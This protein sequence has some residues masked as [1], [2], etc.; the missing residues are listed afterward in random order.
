MI[1]NVYKLPPIDKFETYQ[2][3]AFLESEQLPKDRSV[4][5]YNKAIDTTIEWLLNKM[6][7]E[8]HAKIKEKAM[9]DGYCT[10]GLDSIYECKSVIDSENQLWTLS[11]SQP[12]DGRNMEFEPTPGRIIT[13]NI[14]YHCLGNSVLAAVK[15]TCIQ[16]Y[17]QS[18]KE[19]K[20]ICPSFV[21]S[22][23]REIGLYQGFQ[24]TNHPFRIEKLSDIDKV[25]AYMESFDRTLP[26]L[27]VSQGS[28]NAD[29]NCRNGF[30][31]DTGA[32]A[33]KLLGY[34]VVIELPREY[35][36][37]WLKTVGDKRQSPNESEVVI[38]FPVNEDAD[39]NAYRL[40]GDNLNK[41]ISS[42]DNIQGSFNNPVLREIYSTN[43]RRRLNWDNVLFFYEASIA[44]FGKTLTSKELTEWMET[45]D[46]GNK[47]LQ[48]EIDGLNYT[49][50][51]QSQ[52][53]TELEKRIRRL[54]GTSS[55]LEYI[56][57]SMK[58]VPSWVKDYYENKL[59]LTSQSEGYL[60]ANIKRGLYWDVELVCKTIHTLATSFWESKINPALYSIY[61]KEIESLGL[62]DSPAASKQT[63]STFKDEYTASVTLDGL[64]ERKVVLRDH[65]KKGIGTNRTEY[66]RIYYAWVEQVQKVVVEIVQH[67]PTSKD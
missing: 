52:E 23:I 9:V 57:E 58:E 45:V 16:P 32:I 67:K 21:K 17:I 3:K 48:Q 35:A 24:I 20:V 29:S 66:L 63:I 10:Y 51:K 7:P 53:I 59:V 22:L 50:N 30:V 12:D 64:G 14:S 2:M 11:F 56:P 26:I 33:E 54:K 18:N 60:T 38:C 42:L 13:T 49:I 28:K 47:E 27:L 39:I 1:G 41:F 40:S 44:Y 36:S 31:V 4:A 43:S 19:C 46:K 6:P 15:V 5:L 61:R 34:A 25:S 55:P 37:V 8:C 62:E 65:L